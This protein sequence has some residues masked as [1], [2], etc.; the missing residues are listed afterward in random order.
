MDFNKLLRTTLFACLVSTAGITLAP[1]T[2]SADTLVYGIHYGDGAFGTVDL[3]TGVY[4]QTSTPTPLV[5]DY[6]LAA[7]NGNLYGDD[8][9][10]GNLF[11]LNPSTGAVTHAPT[12]FGQNSDG[13]GS[14]TA[15]LFLVGPGSPASLYSVNPATGAATVIGSTGITSGGGT[16]FLS[17]SNDSSTLYW[18]VSNVAGGT[19]LYSLNTSTGAATLIG[20]Q[21]AY[22]FPTDMVSVGGTLWG[23]IAGSGFFGTINTSTGAET[24]VTSSAAGGFF[25]LAPDPL[26]PTGPP[27][28]PPTV[29]EPA[30]LALLGV[31]LGAIGLLRR[32]YSTRSS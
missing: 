1:A 10:F 17:T 32:F 8:P 14:T 31:G 25:G 28:P 19:S 2:L 11:Q 13:F 29:P 26:S 4:T 15:G 23:Y 18:A 21:A 3:N 16:G 7:F 5:Q 20:S 22:G 27:P 24:L 9:Q 6:E 12:A 30:T